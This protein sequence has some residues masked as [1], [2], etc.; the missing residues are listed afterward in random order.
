[1]DPVR[2]A[3][4]LASGFFLAFG[5]AAYR[6][7]YTV[8]GATAGLVVWMA[9]TETLV[10]LPGL[11]EHPGTASV[12]ILVFLLLT[13]VFLASKFRKLLIFFSGLGTGLILSQTV[14]AIMTEGSLSNAGI[15]LG[16]IDAMD[17]LAG[18]IGGVL[19]LLFERVFAVLLTSVIG[20]FLCTWALGGRWTFMLCL[21][22]GL[23]AQPLIFRKVT[24]PA[25]SGN[26]KNRSGTAA[27]T[28]F[29]LLWLLPAPSIADWQVER[30]QTTTLR[31]VIAA[32]WRDGVKQG[33]NYAVVD[34][35][36]SLIVVMSIGEVYS[37]SS[38]SVTIP[39]ER[40][41]LVDPGMRVMDIEDYEFTQAIE[42][43]GE[44]RLQ[45]FLSKYPSSKNRKVILDALD[46]TRYRL[47][48]LSGTIDAF[49][50]FQRKYPT[51][52]YGAKARKKE[53]ELVFARAWDIGT[54]EAFRA[55]L[56]RFS[57]TKLVSG[58]SEVRAFLNTRKVGK[59]YAYQDFLAAYPRGKLAGEFIP[60]IDE[61]ELWAEKL[62]FG[63]DPVE[64]I[65]HFGELGDETAVPF[66]VGKL[67]VLS[68][69]EE[70]RKAIK[71][72][73]KPALGTL[74]EV[75]ISPL[76]SV[77]L[78]DKVALIIG[79]MGEISTVP[80]LR[81]YYEKE[82]TTGGRKALLMV[83]ESVGK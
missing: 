2:I 20:S 82:K 55:F 43:G 38:Y 39:K 53:E 66:L 35:Q 47:A 28:A 70:A 11:R 27:I 42:Q 78:K 44:P 24:P 30:V 79:E 6:H 19:F 22:I 10:Q 40:L 62:E 64:A 57:G 72:I 59:V 14:A 8:L 33:E 4:L 65:R 75:L 36:G 9:L 80:A 81:S 17:I 49:R 5:L 69:E 21:V 77:E 7:F 41:K 37:D 32:G 61:F 25:S 73:G 16:T 12:L 51:S 71:R 83:E 15:R 52:S 45:E 29:L 1:V 56:N 68:L 60:Y 74:M 34:E 23:V 31:V 54:E 26:G 67:N 50:E 58:M 18:L 13:G 46:E 3:V 48:E 76:Q 63:S